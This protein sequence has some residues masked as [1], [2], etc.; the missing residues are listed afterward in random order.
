MNLSP[1]KLAY[2]VVFSPVIA[3]EFAIGFVLIVLVGITA[4]GAHLWAQNPVGTRRAAAERRRSI[5]EMA[6]NKVDSDFA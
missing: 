2:L 6:L 4:I 1:K 3:V 5:H